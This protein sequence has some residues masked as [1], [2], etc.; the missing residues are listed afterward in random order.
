MRQRFAEVVELEVSTGVA[1]PF[2]PCGF[3][4]QTDEIIGEIGD[5]AFA[6]VFG[7]AAERGV[8][9]EITTGAFPSING[10]ETD[11]HHDDTF[12]RVYAVA[13]EAGC[14]FHLASDTHSLAGMGRVPQLAGGARQLGLEPHHIHPLVRPA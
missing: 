4:E 13:M 7:R 10:G 14:V 8:S 3:V 11:G 1:H 12:L 9:L 6:D 2:L 5:G